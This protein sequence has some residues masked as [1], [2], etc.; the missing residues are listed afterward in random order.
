MRKIAYTIVVLILFLFG[1]VFALSLYHE[2]TL[3][4]EFQNQISRMHAAIKYSDE[5]NYARVILRTIAENEKPPQN[6]QELV[7]PRLNSCSD[8]SFYFFKVW[9]VESGT[10][11]NDIDSSYPISV[12]KEDRV[13]MFDM[14]YGHLN[15]ILQ[16]TI[17]PEK[18][19][20]M[21]ADLVFPL[22]N[23]LFNADYNGD[24]VYDS[25]DVALARGEFNH[26]RN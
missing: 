24:D 14:R 23:C 8:K 13:V 18:A 19:N 17:Y 5:V 20:E 12:F 4:N 26:Q 21:R 2:T 9:I 16:F 1:G 6:W 3:P 25:K 22:N 15:P 7:G 10:T 11:L